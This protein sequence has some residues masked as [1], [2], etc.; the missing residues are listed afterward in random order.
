MSGWYVRNGDKTAGPMS[1]EQLQ[2]YATIGK[3][4]PRY[5]VSEDQV[6]WVMAS[7]LDGLSFPAGHDEVPRVNLLGSL[8][9]APSGHCTY[10]M[11]LVVAFPLTLV[12]AILGSIIGSVLCGLL[13]W[14]IGH[15]A[16]N[17]LG[18][19][20]SDAAEVR[21]FLHPMIV[22]AAGSW[23]G[24]AVGMG[25]GMWFTTDLAAL[26]AK[27]R[28]HEFAILYVFLATLSVSVCFAIVCF[29]YTP[30]NEQLV[31]AI[32]QSI[33]FGFLTIIAAGLIAVLGACSF[34][35]NTP[36]CETCQ[37]YLDEILE[38]RF[39]NSSG[40]IKTEAEAGDVSALEEDASTAKALNTLVRLETCKRGCF[41]NLT[42]GNFAVNAEGKKEFRTAH[43]GLVSSQ[44][45]SIWRQ[46]LKR[47]ASKRLERPQATEHLAS[48]T[49]PT[50]CP[51]GHGKLRD[52]K[53]RLRCWICGW[54][55]K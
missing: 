20:V 29:G 31:D 42:I 36:F 44:Q 12:C 24:L 38:R 3:V 9:Y 35:S 54:P 53:G 45:V 10:P 2:H 49:P 25:V 22:A 1:F 34:I 37:S 8:Q 16:S 23:I 39:R 21:H 5:E 43:E 11:R 7:T 32:N 52:F 41:G 33:P 48:G 46:I 18:Q 15:L 4:K 19:V 47:L 26:W 30:A 27:N 40:E 55:E 14:L 28:N 50:E 17:I 6:T 13:G 51:R